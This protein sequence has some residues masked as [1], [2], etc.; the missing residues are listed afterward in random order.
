MSRIRVLII[1]D[2]PIIAAKIEAA[3]N[4]INFEVAGIAYTPEQ[5]MRLLSTKYPDAALVDIN[6]AGKYEGLVIG[7]A[8]DE[9]YRIPFVYLTAHADR[10][11]LAQ[12]KLTNPAGYIVKPF[13]EEDL[14]V[15][16]ELAMHRHAR[17]SHEVSPG[18]DFDRVNRQLPVPLSSRETDIARLIY[19]GHTNQQMADALEVSVNTIKTHILNLYQKLDV[20]SR[21]QLLAALRD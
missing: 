13:E 17:L 5:A 12:A 8:I 3:L 1:E 14:L 4:N 19:E 20:H 18:L 15:N 11:T 2:E 7:K 9:I 21:S 10:A 6:L 16:L